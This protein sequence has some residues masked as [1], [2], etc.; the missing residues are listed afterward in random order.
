MSTTFERL[1]AVL[2]KYNKLPLDCLTLGAPLASLGIDSAGAVELL[3]NLE[4]A[5]KFKLPPE[6]VDLLTLGDVV[7]Y[8]DQLVAGQSLTL[9]PAAPVSPRLHV[10]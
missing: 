8:V 5:F 1:C 3:W 6:P 10:S 4:G 7:R 9:T 2:V